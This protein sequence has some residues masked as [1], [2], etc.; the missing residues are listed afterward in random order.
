MVQA[1]MKSLGI[2]SYVGTSELFSDWNE[3][4]AFGRVHGWNAWVEVRRQVLLSSS[5]PQYLK[6]IHLKSS[7][8]G[9]SVQP[10][11][12]DA[13]VLARTVSWSQLG[14]DGAWQNWLETDEIEPFK[15]AIAGRTWMVYLYATD[16]GQPLKR[17]PRHGWAM[18]KKYGW[19][20]VTGMA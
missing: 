16:L 15:P 10:E 12:Y 18:P 17:I 4:R 7:L 8:L 2:E 11:L 5:M 20:S 3:S 1:W 6:D 13:I 9:R 19:Y 14:G